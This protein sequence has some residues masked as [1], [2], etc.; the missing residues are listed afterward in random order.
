M[1][2]RIY[3]IGAGQAGPKPL[4]IISHVLETALSCQALQVQMLTV[5]P[6]LELLEVIW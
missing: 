6:F 4:F 2:D 3:Q 5:N 1:F